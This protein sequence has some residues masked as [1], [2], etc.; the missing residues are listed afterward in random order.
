MSSRFLELAFGVALLG[1][2]G[3]AAAAE[4]RVCADPDNLPY[5]KADGSGFEN[6]IAQL[7]AD[8]LHMTLG[9]S[10]QELA[11][12][13]ARKTVGAGE[14]DLLIGVPA[15]FD[16]VLRTKPYY[17]STYVAIA[18]ASEPFIGFDPQ[19]LARRKV[20]VQLIG[21][22][23]VAS[24]PGYALVQAGAIGN[25]TGYPA[26]GDG[27][28]GQRMV[29]DLVHGAIDLGLVWGPQGAYFAR[30]APVPLT[31][32]PAHQPAG[33]SAPFEYSIAM[34]V[35]KGNTELRDKLNGVIDRRRAE[36]DAILAQYDVPRVDREAS[37]P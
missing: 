16:K 5:S 10:W 31:V 34:G 36:I 11:R 25:V 13:F 35:R 28:S 33:I 2:V 24:P 19:A 29:N 9:Y 4:L 22:D 14:C 23:L 8:D 26:Y 17:R 12:G 1:A 27:P 15:G 37:R 18:P 6:R 21:N 20:G 32:T 3:A 30:R 7:V